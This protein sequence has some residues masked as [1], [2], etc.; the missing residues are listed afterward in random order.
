MNW[1]GSHCKGFQTG[2]GVRKIG[3]TWPKTIASTTYIGARKNTSSQMMP[4]MASAGHSGLIRVRPADFAGCGGAS[5]T[6]TG[7]RIPQP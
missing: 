4:G 6:V 1:V 5:V 2:T 3:S 7:V